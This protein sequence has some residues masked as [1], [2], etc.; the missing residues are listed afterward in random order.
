MNHNANMCFQMV[1][2]D[3]YKS[4]VQHKEVAFDYEP[5]I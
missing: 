4:V 1:L 3:P 5:L 2:G